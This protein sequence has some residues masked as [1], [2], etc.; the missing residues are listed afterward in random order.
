MGL[1]HGEALAL[2]RV[3]TPAERRSLWERWRERRLRERRRTQPFA[4]FAAVPAAVWFAMR[5]ESDS[6]E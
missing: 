1:S 2:W 3:M 5:E 4:A 6:D